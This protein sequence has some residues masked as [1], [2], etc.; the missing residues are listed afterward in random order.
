MRP[1]FLLQ[2]VAA[3]AVLGMILL[4]RPGLPGTAPAPGPSPFAAP[5]VDTASPPVDEGGLYV[6]SSRSADPAADR[7]AAGR[8]A[9]AFTRAWAR[10]DLAPD[11][12]WRGV[13]RY[14]EPGY[15]RLL[16]T[17]DPANVPAS[18]VAGAAVP[19][20]AEPGLVVVD[21]PTDAGTCRVT[22]ADEA[23]NGTWRVSTHSWLPGGPR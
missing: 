20:T 3:A 5:T 14:A 2:V 6:P 16:R 9:T 21:V 22:V 19:V 7:R 1:R 17:V 11:V 13:A 12:W 4:I 18:R 15:G 23:G 10:P 8:V